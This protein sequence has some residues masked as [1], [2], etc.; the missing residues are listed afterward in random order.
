MSAFTLRWRSSS[1]PASRFGKTDT[2]FNFDGNPYTNS[3][4]YWGSGEGGNGVHVWAYTAQFGNGL[5]ASLSLEDPAAA[6]NGITNAGFNGGG[7]IAYANQAWPDIVANL[8]VDQAWGS[9]QIMGAIHDVRA[10]DV[11]GVLYGTAPGD[12]TGYALGAGAKLN[13]PTGKGDFITGQVTYTKGALRYITGNN[14]TGNWQQVLNGTGAPPSFGFGVLW[15]AVVTGGGVAHANGTLDLTEGWSLSLGG[16]HHWNPHWKT[17][18]WGD[19]GRITYSD[20]ASNVLAVNIVP[21]GFFDWDLYQIGSRTVWT[22]VTNLDL[23]LEVI[24][25]HLNSGCTATGWLCTSASGFLA[26][27]SDQSWWSGMFRVQR[28]F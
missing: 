27:A 16:E 1:L 7:S 14:G 17:S 8:R 22:P 28:N 25:N 11:G 10:S 2:F 12:D 9:A 13:L 24:Y 20:A 5:S 21:S 4:V 18:L 3:T 6:R 19:Y 23:S 26:P 15:D